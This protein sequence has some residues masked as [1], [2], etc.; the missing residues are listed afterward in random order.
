MENSEARTELDLLD[1]AAAALRESAGVIM[2]VLEHE[3]DAPVGKSNPGAV[4][5]INGRTFLT[6]V[7]RSVD[8]VD[9]LRNAHLQLRSLA[10][11]SAL[12][13]DDTLLVTSHLTPHLLNACRELELNAVDGSGNAHLIWE[14]T[15]VVVSGRPRRTKPQERLGWTATAVRLALIALTTP[16]TLNYSQRAIATSAGISLGSVGPALDWL[17][18]RRFLLRKEAGITVARR[19]ELLTEWSVAYPARLRPRLH[20]QHFGVPSGTRW[21]A[22]AEVG[23]GEWSG[24]VAAALRHGDLRPATAELYVDPAARRDVVRRLVREFHLRP[25]PDG[26]LT[27]FDR[28]WGFDNAE[29]SGSAPWPVTYADLLQIGDP[30]TTE[31]AAKIKHDAHVD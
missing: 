10:E 6:E 2:E 4:V 28:F 3:D 29:G 13:T 23:P 9:G 16:E 25:D 27:V 11:A 31:A 12:T 20:P 30:R 1:L 19:N 14:N 17:E 22:T 26:E 21:W 7:K 15:V 18:S 5:W 24:E 8:R